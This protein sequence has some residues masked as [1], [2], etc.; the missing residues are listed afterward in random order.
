MARRERG[1]EGPR[2][3]VSRPIA[4]AAWEA[5]SLTTREAHIVDLVLQGHSS[6][7]I[8]WRLGIAAGTVKVHRR[9]V[10]RKLNISSQTELL[11]IYVDRIVG[12]T[13]AQ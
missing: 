7:S 13:W 10:Y 4:V 1:Y 6:E 5:L 11:S 9:N 12:Q 3:L 8:A 2:S